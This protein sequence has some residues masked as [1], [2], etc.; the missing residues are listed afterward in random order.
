MTLIEKYKND[1]DLVRQNLTLLDNYRFDKNSSDSKH[2]DRLRLNIAIYNDLKNT[3]YEIVKF[4]F[5]EEKEWRKYGKDGEVD[6]LYFSAY[7]LTHFSNPETIWLFF[8]TKNIDFD[9]GIGFDGEYLLFLGIDSTYKYIN[10]IENIDKQ[11]LL[12]YIGATVEECQYSQED[13]DRW[14]EFKRE[15]FSN[16]E[17]PIKNEIGFLY[18]INEKELFTKLFPDWVEQQQNWSYENL[19]SY[20]TF[21]KYIGD[22]QIEIEAFK[23]SI[24]KNDKEFMSDIYKRQLAELYIDICDFENSFE[25]LKSVI[26]GTDNTNIIRD[27]IEQLCRIIKNNKTN[28]PEISQSSYDIIIREQDKYRHFSPNVDN[29]ISEVREMFDNQKITAHNTRYKILGFKWLFKG[30]T[31]IKFRNG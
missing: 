6:N 20:R 12:K 13:I 25:I 16:Y 4:L 2:F 7:L 15:Y 29:L 1:L 21:A 28:N 8:E 3:D 27:C 10:S 17:Y 26:K 11:K 19:G 14:K 24:A 5:C 31:R 22:K 9:S 18:L 23:L 30:I